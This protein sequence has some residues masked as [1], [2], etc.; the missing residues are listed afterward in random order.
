MLRPAGPQDAAAAH[1]VARAGMSTYTAFAGP[2][3]TPPADTPE[4][5]AARLARGWGVLA[6]HRGEA[7]GFGAAEAAREQSRAGAL[8]P[9]LAHVWAI[10]VA[11]AHWGTGL[12]ARLLTAVLDEAAGRGFA[13]ARLHTPA[14]QARARRFYAREGWRETGGPQW[15]AA[16]GLDL[17]ELRRDL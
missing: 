14:L 8:V 12:A 11:E 2:G 4:M 17:V 13:E 1:A 15:V 6:E 9:G 3:W 7:V 16:T 10:F 5:I